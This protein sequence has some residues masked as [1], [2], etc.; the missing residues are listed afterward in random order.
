MKIAV[1]AGHCPGLD[2]GAVG[3]NSEE[4][5][6]VKSVAHALCYELESMGHTPLFIQENEL[7]DICDIANEAEADIFV[8]IHC[9][10]YNG[11][12]HGTET[13]CYEYGDES[14]R[15]ADCVQKELLFTLG[16][17]DRGIKTK[18]DGGLYVINHTDM[19][20]ILIEL[21][22]IDNPAEED[23]LNDNIVEMARAIARGIR[24]HARREDYDE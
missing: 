4:A 11:K 21:A 6:I 10:A 8:S 12:A 5:E 7:E 9:N 20:A 15:L 1:N 22:F 18:N 14:Y 23:I 19:P 24:S 3:R 2:S 17:T 16:T 13:W